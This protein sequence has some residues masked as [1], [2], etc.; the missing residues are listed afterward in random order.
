M[1]H[2]TR[3][4]S[5]RTKQTLTMKKFDLN[6]EKILEN[7]DTKHAVREI[8]ANALDEQKLTNSGEIKIVKDNISN[9]W[10]ITDFGR[11]LKYEHFTQNEN[12]E[13]LNSNGIIG[14]FGIGLKDAM[15]TFE[16][17]GITVRILSKY[18]DIT[19]GKSQKTGFDDLITL[20]AYISEPTNK[21]LIGTEFHLKNISDLDIQEGKKLFLKFNDEP[22]I[23]STKYGSVLRKLG[24]QGKIYI[25]GVL[26]ATEENFLFSYNITLLNAS[27]KKAINRERTNV[28]RTAYANTVKSILLECQSEEIGSK[29][30]SD[31][32]QYS[33]GNSHDEL[34]WLDVQEHTA[35]ILHKYR[36]VVFVTAQEIER[37]T[38]L[39][40]EARQGGA[41]IVVIPTNLRDKIAS[42]NENEDDENKVRIFTEF[43]QERSE[44][45]EFKIVNENDLNET[46]KRVFSKKDKIFQ[47][48][49]GKPY[50]IKS[51][52]VS[53]TMQKDNMTFSQAAAIWEPSSQRIIIW[54]PKLRNEQ[55]FLGI[56]LHEISHATSGATDATRAFESEL[57]RL[58]GVVSIRAISTG[59]YEENLTYSSNLPTVTP[60]NE[61]KTAKEI[62]NQISSLILIAI[63]DNKSVKIVY[64]NSDG[65]ESERVLSNLRMVTKNGPS[66]HD[67]SVL[68]ADCNLRGTERHFKIDRI[69][70]IE[71]L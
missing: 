53:D 2:A 61:K 43:V 56:L 67:F 45:F 19:L 30:S 4:T 11:G 17:K 70:G 7:W 71:L 33:Y 50:N 52:V 47:L 54:R 66:G 58:L 9:S 29:L 60:T 8:I 48:I 36:R 32:T 18:G 26:V 42:Q 35:K 5:N 57:T 44:N 27:V 37:G 31:L 46:E 12:D 16:R 6:I 62:K 3:T 41:E 55:E 14:R 20:H 1:H 63:E 68:K 22:V 65:E 15:A 34:K 13:K 10:V 69:K 28:G 64:K 24:S 38:D 49:G 51:V 59:K 23:E 21:N 25:N 39:V 40:N